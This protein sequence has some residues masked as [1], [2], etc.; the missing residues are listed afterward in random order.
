MKDLTVSQIERQNVLNNRF[1]VDKIQ[2]QLNLEG[3]FFEGQYWLTKKMVTDFY[4]VDERTIERC[5]SQNEEELKH[6]GYVL[7]R[8][9]MLKEFKLRFAPV[10]NVG[11]KTTQLGLFYFRAFLNL[12][13]LLTESE[14]AK[15]VRSYEQ[16]GVGYTR[17]RLRISKEEPQQQ[18]TPLTDGDY[19]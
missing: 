4:D 12:G 8:G 14:Q 9:K 11:S 19:L 3:L 5:V 7:C 2:E 18:F 1:A 6:N 10:I 17:R 13:M 16:W 15:K